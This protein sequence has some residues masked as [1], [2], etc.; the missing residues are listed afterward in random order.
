MSYQQWYQNHSKKHKKIL[1][2]IL[3]L[4]KDAI[5]EYFL[6]DN[7]IKNEPDF[8]T[9]YPKNKKCHESSYLNCYF[10][11]CPNYR[12]YNTI[13]ESTRSYCKIE[14]KDGKVDIKDGIKHQNCL[15]C[16]VPHK[17]SYIKK[18]FTKNILNQINGEIQ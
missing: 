4:D 15:G 17:S 16:L 6:Y 12:Y 9:L 1:Q 10:C 8:C 7:M 11:A 2:K 14:S 5:I 13:Q 3:H 18:N